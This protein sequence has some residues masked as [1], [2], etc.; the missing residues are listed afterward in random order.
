MFVV[1]CGASIVVDKQKGDD[2]STVALGP[3]LA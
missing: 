3:T 1:L 2:L